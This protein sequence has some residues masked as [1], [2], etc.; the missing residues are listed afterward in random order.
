M[1]EFSCRFL[2]VQKSSIGDLVTDGTFTIQRPVTFETFDW[3]DEETLS[4]IFLI[5]DNFEDFFCSF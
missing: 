2:A 4:D 3:S 5:V 1:D